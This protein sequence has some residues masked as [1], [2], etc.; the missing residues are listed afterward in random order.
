MRKLLLL[1][2][3]IAMPAF[4]HSGDHSPPEYCM[5]IIEPIYICDEMNEWGYV[6]IPE[7][8]GVGIEFDD[9]I[10]AITSGVFS[11]WTGIQ[12]RMNRPDRN[13]VYPSDTAVLTKID[14]F[15]VITVISSFELTNGQ[16][17][18]KARTTLR[19]NWY[20]FDAET[21]QIG[22]VYTAEHA[23]RHA[24]MLK[25]LRHEWSFE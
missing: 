2:L 7:N 23:A 1:L 12:V 19:F 4:T 8:T 3:C 17:Y 24:D 20:S 9:G 22:D 18:T 6:D 5:I 21:T 15:P 10:T 11:P 14:R 13:Q 16:I 25:A